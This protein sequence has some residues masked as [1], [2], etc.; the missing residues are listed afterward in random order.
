ME[1][2]S[3]EQ[4]DGFVLCTQE[5]LKKKKRTEIFGDQGGLLHEK[6]LFFVK[7]DL[8]LRSARM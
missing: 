2:E 3:V 6:D 4:T 8:T 7:C 1:G 5:S